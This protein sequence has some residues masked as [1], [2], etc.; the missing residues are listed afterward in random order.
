MTDQTTLTWRELIDATPYDPDR[1]MS[2]QHVEAA[3]RALAEQAAQALALLDQP[4]GHRPRA[5]H[6][7]PG[8]RGEP[9]PS[10]GLPRRGLRR[11]ARRRVPAAAGGMTAT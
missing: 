10:L 7:Q 3:L 1:R 11:R 8:A 4:V 6:R 9:L 2:V 5:D